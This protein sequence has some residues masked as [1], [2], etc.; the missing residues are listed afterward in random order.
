VVILDPHLPVTWYSACATP[1]S[2]WSIMYS[3]KANL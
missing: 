3:W 1:K 2:L